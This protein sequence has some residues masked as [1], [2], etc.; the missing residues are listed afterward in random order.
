MQ[1]RLSK[2]ESRQRYAEGRKLWNEF[3]PIG[4]VDAVDDEYDSYI[5]PCLRFAEM[6]KS[7]EELEEYVRW[8]VYEHMGLSETDEGNKANLVFAKKFMEWYRADWPDTT[9]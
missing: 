7:I 5:G 9:V 6:G 4:V 3:D 1:R 8:V 2:E